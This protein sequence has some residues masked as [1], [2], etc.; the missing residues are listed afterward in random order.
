[1]HGHYAGRKFQVVVNLLDSIAANFRFVEALEI[2]HCDGKPLNFV[3]DEVDGE[4]ITKTI[5]FDASADY[6]KNFPST[7]PNP[8]PLAAVFTA[9]AYPWSVARLDSLPHSAMLLCSGAPCYLKYS[10]AYG[11][12]Q[13]AE[14]IIQ[15]EAGTDLPPWSDWMK[16]PDNQIKASVSIDMWSFGTPAAAASSSSKQQQQQQQQQHDD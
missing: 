3:I 1:M 11:S 10:S 15:Y 6:G 7:S 12:P 16:Q 8:V 5:D 4:K 9:C 14:R 2:S 13:L